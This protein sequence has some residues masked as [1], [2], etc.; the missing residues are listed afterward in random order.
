[1]AATGEALAPAT[2]PPEALYRK[3]SPGPGKSPAEVA[4]H[5]R[6][7][8]CGAM[9]EIAGERGY[10]AVTVRELAQLA[11]VSTRAFYEHFD[12]KE[13]CFLSAH[14]LVVRQI[15]AAGV[16]AQSGQRDWRKRLRLS[17]AAFAHEMEVSPRATRVV[18]VEPFTVGPAGLERMRRTEGIFEAMISESFSRSPD[19]IDIPP[20]LIKGVVTGAER[21]ARGRVLANRESEL[22]DLAGEIYEWALCFHDSAT[23]ELEKLDRRSTLLLANAAARATRESKADDD[24]ERILIAA[25]KLSGSDG[26]GELTVPRIRVAAGVSRRSF[27]S[28]FEGV[29]DCFIAALERKISSAFESAADAR[30]AGKSWAG[31]VYRAIATLC[32]KIARD[33]LLAKLAFSEI[34]APGLNGVHCRERLAKATVELLRSE[35]PDSERPSQLAAEA[36]IGAIWG[37]MHHHVVNGRAKQLP[38]L[39]ATLSY[40]PLAPA[41]GPSDAT[42]AIRT[43]QADK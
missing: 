35:A 42:D 43:E 6:A 28:H 19:Q 12:G 39:A 33:P 32:V 17:F 30:Q 21:V 15:A 22:P 5:Q 20:L 11:G 36:S 24:R 25:A 23:A 26:Y 16:A 1:V 40:L 7:R 10:R 14:E 13:E 41:V 18:L 29:E 38:W 4:S 8:I 27:N 31:G 3:L 34:F 2:G 37:V 9:V